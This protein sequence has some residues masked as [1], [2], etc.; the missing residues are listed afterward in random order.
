MRII[1]EYVEFYIILKA[2][3]LLVAYAPEL[4][5]IRC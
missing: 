2:I 4:N 1:V 5:K 3:I